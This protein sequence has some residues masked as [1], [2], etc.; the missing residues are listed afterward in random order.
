MSRFAVLLITYASNLPFGNQPYALYISGGQP[1]SAEW[2]TC[3]ANPTAISITSTVADSNLIQ[4]HWLVVLVILFSAGSVL[5]YI[6]RR[7]FPG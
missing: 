2:Q 7:N 5:V 4:S 6:T 3:G 1:V